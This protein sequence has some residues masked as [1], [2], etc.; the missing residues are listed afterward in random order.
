MIRSHDIVGRRSVQMIQ[1]YA[2]NYWHEMPVVCETGRYKN[3]PVLARITVVIAPPF[4]DS[5]I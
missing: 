1:I 4:V 2:N 3:P 5:T